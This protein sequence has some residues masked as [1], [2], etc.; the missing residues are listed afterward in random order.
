[1]HIVTYQIHPQIPL[2]VSK[3]DLKKKKGY[4]EAITCYL[5]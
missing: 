1:M 5:Q 4:K 2:M 3:V